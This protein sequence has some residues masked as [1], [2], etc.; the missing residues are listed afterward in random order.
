VCDGNITLQGLKAT[1]LLVPMIVTI[2]HQP[3]RQI[4]HSS[5][6]MTVSGNTL[7]V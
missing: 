4:S 5:Q 2:Q 3:A 7:F 6:L 1:G